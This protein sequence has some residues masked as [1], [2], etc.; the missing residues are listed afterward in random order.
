MTTPIDSLKQTKQ[1]LHQIRETL[2]PFLALLE[3]AYRSRKRSSHQRLTHNDTDSTQQHISSFQVAEAE[4]AVALAMGTLRFMARRLQGKGEKSTGNHAPT[5]DPLRLELEKMRKVLTDLKQLKNQKDV[6][7]SSQTRT[8][9]TST[10]DLVSP[11]IALK[12]QGTVTTTLQNEDN[13]DQHVGVKRNSDESEYKP[14]L[15][16]TLT[17]KETRKRE[18]IDKQEKTGNGDRMTKGP[19]QQYKKQRKV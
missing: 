9:T 15:R 7:S 11:T 13:T 2:E 18:N 1:A 19:S 6:I 16:P 5:K 4:A 17:S 12:S 8:S 10:N 14:D 3:M